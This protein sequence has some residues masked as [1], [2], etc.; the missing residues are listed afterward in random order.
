MIKN[1]EEQK[2]LLREMV[3][4]LTQEVAQLT[5]LLTT[6]ESKPATLPELQP[7]LQRVADAIRELREQVKTFADQKPHVPAQAVDSGE[8]LTEL[9][10]MRQEIRKSPANRI[11][12]AVQYGAGLLVVSLLLTG[13]LAYYA[14]KWRTERDAFEVSDWKWRA[15][16]QDGEEYA[17][18]MDGAFDRD[19]T[20]EYYKKRI[21]EMEQADATR[22]AAQRAAEQAK[23]MNAQ[24][25]ELEGRKKEKK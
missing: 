23:A 10:A 19:S 18:K 16:R 1:E 2:T 6:K 22:E 13:V 8:L 24:A 15:V 14:S 5:K 20:A 4:G 12:K 9:R 17:T 3:E 21:L 7:F 25:D 11:S